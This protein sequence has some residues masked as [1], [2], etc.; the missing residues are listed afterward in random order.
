MKQKAAASQPF[1]R[2]GGVSLPG[3]GVQQLGP[4]RSAN[5]KQ[6]QVLIKHVLE[7]IICTRYDI[8]SYLS[9]TSYIWFIANELGILPKKQWTPLN[10]YNQ[11]VWVHQ[12]V[13]LCVNTGGYHLAWPWTLFSVYV[14]QER[15]TLGVDWRIL[16]GGW[17]GRGRVMLDFFRNRATI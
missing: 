7:T 6:K 10:R 2:K 8:M 14:C 11:S 5:T 17:L 12:V 15:H 4:E 16:E 1:P 9:D 3:K 13:L